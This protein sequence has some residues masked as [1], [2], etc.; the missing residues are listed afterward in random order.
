MNVNTLNNLLAQGEIDR[1]DMWPRFSEL[2]AKAVRFK[3]EFGLDE[4]PEEPGLITIRG[5]R[6]YGKSTW[7]E[8]SLRESV[9]L[10]GKGSAFYLN[11]DEIPSTDRLYEEMESLYGAYSADVRVR[12]LFIDE[13]TAVPDWEKAIKRLLDQGIFKD[14]LIVTTGSKASDLRRFS[15]RL[16]GRKGRLRKSDYIFL[17]ISYQ[18]FRRAT[19]GKLGDKTWIAYLL[20]GGSPVA[21][22][23]IYRF[24][25]LPEYFIQLTR[26]WI[27]GEIV[28]SGRSRISLTQILQIIMKYGG[29]SVG[30]AK[31][32]RESGLANNTVAGGYVEQLSDL[33]ALLP[34]FPLDISRN[35]FQLRKPCKFHFI[36]LAAATA[37]HPSTPRR[38]NEYEE[39]E[40]QIQSHFL[41][42]L[43]AQE[44]WR[45]A[46]LSD[47]E[48]PEAIGFWASKE[49]EIDFVTP[50][51]Q[52]IEV[53]RGKSN[54]LEFVWFTKVFPGRH[55]KVITDTP[56]RSKHVTG[57]TI[58]QFLMLRDP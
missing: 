53:K 40:P 46:V 20:T 29:Q 42:W 11:G 8:T 28:S 2:K 51:G 48:N 30:F 52:M 3:F 26:D 10:F 5:P 58:E 39:M 50:E 19:H 56:F 14:V 6:Q 38:I 33:L 4:L 23:D 32:A 25:K 35:V 9:K 21:C 57:L 43:V 55:L 34:S 41:E 37:F 54:P 49:H 15:E 1:E 17:P 16:P 44:L 18:E 13:I 45:R 36:N 27:L 31:L 12:R 22:H 47:A 7:L 24:G